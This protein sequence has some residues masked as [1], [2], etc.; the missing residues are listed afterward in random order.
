MSLKTIAVCAGMIF[1]MALTAD[2]VSQY[3]TN[4]ETPLPPRLYFQG[5][6]GENEPYIIFGPVYEKLWQWVSYN[7]FYEYPQADGSSFDMDSKS[8]ISLL[9]DGVKD[10][11]FNPDIEIFIHIETVYSL[12]EGNADLDIELRCD[13]DGDGNFEY[14]IDFP[15]EEIS[16]RFGETLRSPDEIG[17]PINMTDGTMELFIERTDPSSQILPIDC[18]YE[19]YIQTPFDYDTDS[20]G[21]GDF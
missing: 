13:G 15:E 19:S 21:I 3:A 10:M 2:V 9:I 11:I 16:I 17:N 4:Y 5:G 14:I 7:Y 20:D 18:T 8:N 1:V 12:V 6:V